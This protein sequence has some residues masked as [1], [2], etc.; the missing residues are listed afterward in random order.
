MTDS[1][2]SRPRFSGLSARTRPLP[3]DPRAA[4]SV[5]SG[6][7]PQDAQ[8]PAPEEGCPGVLS[9]IVDRSPGSAALRSWDE[10]VRSCPQSD[11]A[12]LSGW[13]RVRALVG[14]E[15]LYVFVR[16]GARLVAGAQ[17]LVRQIPLLGRFGYVPYGPLVAPA[18]LRSTAVQETLATALAEVARQHRGLFV[19]PPEQGEQLSAALIR[20]GFRPSDAKVTPSTSLRVDLSLDEA[21]LRHNLSRRLRG[22]THQWAARGVTV[23]RGRP[24]DLPLAARLHALTAVH[25]GFT[26]LSLDYLAAM[27]R[28]LSPS[29]HFFVLIGEVDGQPGAMGAYTGN[30]AVLKARLVGLDRTAR[31]ARL[32]VVAAVDWHALTW[33]KR[34][35]YRWFD[36]SGLGAQSLAALESP[37]RAD[38]GRLPGPDR[39][40]L[41]FGGEPFRY[42]QP[43]ERVSP[44]AFQ[45]TIDLL[46]RSDGGQR[47][48]EFARGWAR[49]GSWRR[50]TSSPG[51]GW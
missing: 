35:G 36:F 40:K 23:R 24:E 47:V 15:P 32:D 28:E 5:A 18:A 12:Q 13:A 3:A 10:F 31:A 22:W 39:Y 8:G 25:Q 2:A 1:R 42:P 16:N 6:I 37:G 41:R 21:Q 49:T 4:A 44:P 45:I 9:V 29:G 50:G 27:D 30:G 17:V 11:V 46:R 34:N 38:L 26:P 19:Q 48:M 20:R 43:V 7:G 33:A 14:Y 51:R